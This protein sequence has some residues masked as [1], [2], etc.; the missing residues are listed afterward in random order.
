MKNLRYL[1]ILLFM[2]H[3]AV[4]VQAQEP[5]ITIRELSITFKDAL[6][7]IETQSLY[8]IGYVSTGLDTDRVL[9]LSLQDAS[10]NFAIETILQGTSYTY[11]IMGR[12]I[13]L[14]PDEN[15]G[16]N[17]RNLSH[18]K[19]SI[20]NLIPAEKHYLL[21]DIL[22]TASSN[23]HGLNKSR[24]Q[25][26]TT[27]RQGTSTALGLLDHIH[28]LRYDKI[29]GRVKT[30]GDETAL[31][32]VNGIKQPEEYF[33]NLSP[34]R[35]EAVEVITEPNGRYVTDGYTTLVNLLLKENYTG[36]DLHLH[37]Q[38]IAT[39]GNNNGGEWLANMLPGAGIN[40][41]NRCISFFANYLLNKNHW[42]TP[43][44]KR[45]ELTGVMVSESEPLER[46]TSVNQYTSTANHIETGINYN[47]NPQHHLV[48][49]A[50]YMGED[51]NNRD[52][53]NFTNSI[54]P[55]NGVVKLHSLTSNLTQADD[56]TLSTF[57]QGKINKKIELYTDIT[58]NYYSNKVE[59]K[60]IQ[61]DDYHME[62]FYS[63]SKNYLSFNARASYK[64]S[65][66][67]QIEL[68]YTYV[69][70]M[71]N[72]H[73]TDNFL[74]LKHSEYQSRPYLSIAWQP[75]SNISILA[76]AG[77]EYIRNEHDE[78]SGQ[79][80]YSFQPY[81]RVAYRPAKNI[82]LGVAYTTSN[83]YATLFQLSR[84]MTI[85]DSLSAYTGNPDLQPAHIRRVTI[86]ADYADRL[87]FKAT[88][89]Y[90]NNGISEVNSAPWIKTFE[91]IQYRQ[92]TLQAIYTQPFN[93][94]TQLKSNITLYKDRALWGDDKNSGRGWLMESEF[95]YFHPSLELG[96]TLGYIRNLRHQTLPQGYQTSGLD[97]WSLGLNKLFFN[98]RASLALFWYPPV[99][100]G[101][102]DI[103]RK[104]ILTSYHTEQYDLSTKPYQNMLLVKFGFRFGNGKVNR[105][106]KASSVSK[107]K[108]RGRTVDFR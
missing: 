71:Y 81:L 39:P 14:I 47:F 31:L 12:H 7:E 22:V 98:G 80:H 49:Q 13:I 88:Y 18:S 86:S 84:A 55:G 53:F 21:E 34:D 27:M 68:L 42:N 33:R 100:W 38:G 108:R 9:H 24:Y 59:S 51:E 105:P 44:K 104:E 32:L 29:S 45:Q 43:L 8:T 103:Q 70:R 20:V 64:L 90:T 28:N 102:R 15:N 76:G 58:Y 87:T 77:M 66:G 78:S 65:P 92:Y 4:A 50:V 60:Y 85:N 73:T 95:A 62:R 40:Y 37:A 56:Y 48:L 107:E 83:E 26:T 67:W 41:T 94:Y 17:Y 69:N 82:R 3:Y 35:I 36:Y 97:T 72:S 10:L 74:L 30:A 1:Y 5:K 57:Y 79:S 93:K 19:D 25:I 16:S 2:L 54:Q 99:R 106:G 96:A 52:M 101:I 23:I 6:R 46:K 75:N 89:T 91:N 61:S 11:R 63:E